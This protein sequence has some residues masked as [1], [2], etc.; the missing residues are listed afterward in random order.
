MFAIVQTLLQEKHVKKARPSIDFEHTLTTRAAW[1]HYVGGHK[2]NDVAKILGVTS[3]KAHRLIAKAVAE[4]L[5][6]VSI[7]GDI[8]DCIEMEREFVRRFGLSVCEISPDLLE[9]GLPF[10]SLG[11]AGANFLRRQIVLGQHQ[12]IGISHGRT[13]AAAMQQ[14]APLDAKNIRFVSLLGGLTRNFAANPHDVMHLLAEKT[15]APAYVMPV[16]FY[17]NSS[18]DRKVLLA[19]KGVKNVF[20]LAEATTL[21]LVG[22]GTIGENTQLVKSGMIEPNEIM[23][24]EAEGGVCELLG[25]FY[26]KSGKLIQTSLTYRT[27]AVSVGK[28]VTGDVIALAGGPEKVEP[29]C[30]AL[31]SKQ[32]SGLITDERT[33]KALLTRFETRG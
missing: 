26:D 4:G 8:V 11:M 16:P 14:L 19:Q 20:D 13:L 28:K 29:L 15:R 9:D 32:L 24:I 6:K 7:D 18:D 17:A 22:I 21:K 5:V 33:A 3:V 10:R 12:L 23:E 31:E 2:Q 25:R 30:A 1:L 27:L